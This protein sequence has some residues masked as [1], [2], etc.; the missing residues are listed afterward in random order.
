[1]TPDGC[2]RLGRRWKLCLAV[3]FAFSQRAAASALSSGRVLNA[4]AASGAA[5]CT[6]LI[7]QPQNRRG[8][9]RPIKN[10]CS[11]DVLMVWLQGASTRNDEGHSS[12]RG[13]LSDAPTSDDSR[14][15]TP[16]TTPPSIPTNSATG[17]KE[18]VKCAA[19][20]P[21]SALFLARLWGCYHF[22][23]PTRQHQATH[24]FTAEPVVRGFVLKNRTNQD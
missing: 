20:A 16:E 21:L 14:L 12:W 1:V 5:L 23:Y 10:D 6:A 11:K 8:A 24:G 17:P 2:H 7:T 19:A 4:I 13:L 22:C 3:Q 18:T 15:N 9:Q